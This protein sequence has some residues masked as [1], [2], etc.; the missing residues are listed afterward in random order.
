MLKILNYAFF[1][2]TVFSVSITDSFVSALCLKIQTF[3]APVQSHYVSR[4][5]TRPDMTGLAVPCALYTRTP[6][7]TTHA[8]IYVPTQYEV[9]VHMLRCA[10]T[11]REQKG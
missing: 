6:D 1:N 5:P 9:I 3:S 7:Q 11:C 8:A 4:S 2:I 10:C